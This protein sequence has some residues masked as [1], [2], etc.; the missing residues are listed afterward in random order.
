MLR[1][2][3]Q[4]DRPYRIAITAAADDG[5]LA[6]DITGPTGATSALSLTVDGHR[7]TASITPTVLGDHTVEI[8]AS[9]DATL[10]GMQMT[11]VVA[12]LGPADFVADPTVTTV[13]CSTGCVLRWPA[14]D[15]D[16]MP[17]IDQYASLQIRR[18]LHRATSKLFRDTAAR[19]PGCYCY[20]R[21]R[22]RITG[23]CL[24][25]APSGAYG[26]DLFD[27]LRYPAVEL[28]DVTVDGVTQPDDEWVIERHRWLVPAEGVSWPT[29]NYDVDDGSVG[30]WSVAVR[31]GRQVDDIVAD[32]RDAWAY[33][34]ILA[35]TE[36]TSG[37]MACK[38]PDG[39]TQ[40]T[41]N[42]RVIARDPQYTVS[43]L[44]QQVAEM[45]PASPW[46]L[47]QIVDPAEFSAR[48]SR[49]A[50]FVPGDQTPAEHAVFLGSGADIDTELAGP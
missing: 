50:R 28:L 36:T 38:L 23:A 18:W 7:H 34:M 31:Y 2:T 48:G 29:Q 40:I 9:D 11:L 47:S 22:P 41:E 25:L 12:E 33:S 17:C 4:L 35:T 21:L 49:F 37:T 15:F 6:A 44:L 30:S 19:F 3:A 1:L 5:T 46:D 16:Q 14:P 24:S 42:G 20:A 39:T 45:F 10:V 26:F 27:S 43:V 32:A 13:G 8:T